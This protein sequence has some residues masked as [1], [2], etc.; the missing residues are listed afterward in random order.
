MGVNVPRTIAWRSKFEQEIFATRDV[1]EVMLVRS[2]PNYGREST[3][4]SPYFA[5]ILE[6]SKAGEDTVELPLGLSSTAALM[7]V[8]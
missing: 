6:G 8:E 5:A 7:H 4:W 3:F 1:L 2:S